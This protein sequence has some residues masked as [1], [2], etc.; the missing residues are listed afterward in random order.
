[1]Y[2]VYVTYAKNGS[3]EL[4]LRAYP[5]RCVDLSIVSRS[6]SRIPHTL[7]GREAGAGLPVLA[8]SIPFIAGLQ[9][10]PIGT[11]TRMGPGFFPL[12][13]VLALG[14]LAVALILTG[15]IGRAER[16]KHFSRWDLGAFRGVSVISA[17]I[18]AFIAL[19]PVFGL[20][21][22]VFV[23]SWLCSMAK[24]P[25]HPWVATWLATFNAGLVWVVF[26]LFLELPIQAVSGGWT[27]IS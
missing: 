24:P 1:M 18:I 26:I 11:S 14:F 23:T 20:I 21:P 10:L 16:P 4:A 7:G 9:T 19:L 13:V 8:L 5:A 12:V 15:L 25:F 17:A 3:P 2:Q 27:W 6:L 22:A